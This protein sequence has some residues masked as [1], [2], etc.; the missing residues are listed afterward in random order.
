MLNE[1]F[2]VLSGFPCLICRSPTTVTLHIVQPLYGAGSIQ[3][4]G[5]NWASSLTA[6]SAHLVLFTAE[7]PESYSCLP[8]ML[9]GNGTALQ[10]FCL[11]NPMDGGAW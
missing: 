11:E 9:K 5:F 3:H 7:D 1:D 2:C 6:S 8:C 4:S 10:Y